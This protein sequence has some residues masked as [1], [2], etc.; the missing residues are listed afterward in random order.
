[1]YPGFSGGPLVSSSGQ[2]A[3]M[4]STALARGAPVA[5]PHATISRV[6][7][8]ILAHGKVKRGYLGIGTYPVRLQGAQAQQA[9]QETGLLVNSVEPGSP[10]EKGG[11]LLGDIVVAL[12]GQSARFPD[13]LLASLGGEKVGKSAH[14][15]VV[16]GGQVRELAVV[17]GERR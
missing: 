14:L 2:F 3:G 5:I 7:E 15:T 6:V 10:A 11:V 9:K 8:A 4:N 13:D 12:D 17:I 16:R 1:M